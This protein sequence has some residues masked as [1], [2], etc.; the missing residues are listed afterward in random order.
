METY[1]YISLKDIEYPGLIRI[2]TIG[3]GSCF[4][5]SV[6]RAFS[7]TYLELNTVQDRIAYSKIL[8][9]LLADS[10]M[11]IGSNGKM[12]YDNLS[13]GNLREF[14]K[15]SPEYELGNLVSELKSSNPVDNVYHELISNKLN[16]DIYIIN[17]TKGNIYTTGT[18]LSLIFKDRNSIFLGYIEPSGNVGVG[19]FEVIGLKIGERTVTLFKNNHPFTLYIR[20]KFIKV[21]K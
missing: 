9:N 17:L 6:L 21:V 8:R 18:D 2:T 15:Y 12:L 16:L 5:H 1:S 20:N 14:S 7:K 19:N 11:E 3:D 13:K 10:L 4:F